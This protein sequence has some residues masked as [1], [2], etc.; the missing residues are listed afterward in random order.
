MQVRLSEDHRD[1]RKFTLQVCVIMGLLSGWLL[2]RGAIGAV[3]CTIVL[4]GWGLIGLLAWTFP[5]WFRGFYRLGMLGSA[6][7]GDHV[8]RVILTV[9]FFVLLLPLGFVLRLTGH[10]P[11]ALQAVVGGGQ[12]YWRPATKPGNL[13]Q[14]Y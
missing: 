7:L 11:L 2:W 4:G 5:H 14:M 10:D 6:W 1:W 8:G 3:I 12:G 13:E 9:I